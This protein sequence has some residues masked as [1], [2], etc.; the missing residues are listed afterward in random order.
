M[1]LVT[2]GTGLLGSH[3]LLRLSD[4]RSP[5]RA[6]YRDASRIE[7]TK[8]LFQ[9]Y[10]PIHGSEKF[11][12]IEWVEG[13]ILDIPSLEDAMNGV[14]QVYHCAGFVSF[15]EKHFHQLMKI[16]REGTANVINVSLAA[17]VE[18]IC[19]VSSTAA[20]GSDT[21]ENITEEVKW[22]QSPET[23]GYALS[24]YSAEKEVW[25][26]VE[27]G[28]DAIIVNPSVIFGAGSWDESSLAIFRTVYNG[29]RFYTSGANAFVDA[30]DVAD[31]MVRLMNSDTKNERFLCTGTNISF[32]EMTTLIAHKL[33]KKAP[34]ISAPRWLMG[35]AWRIS[36][37]NA[38]LRGKDP[39][40]TRASARSAYSSITFDP[41]KVKERLQLQFRPLKETVED[42]IKG[43]LDRT[44]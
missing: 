30:R 38:K 5:V 14:R 2:G 25:R 22:K 44:F 12:K 13:D 1:I 36:W 10:D 7:K 19:H 39:T 43:R 15:A 31:I 34:S 4:E 6:L 17:Q 26:G 37:I 8:R 24:K 21:R 11:D 42:T 41:S 32:R 27:E 18:K 29:L 35:L 40:V 16:N 33:G 23:S 9:F 3:L 28:L 20:L